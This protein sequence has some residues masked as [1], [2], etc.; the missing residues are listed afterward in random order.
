MA[1]LL[2]RLPLSHCLI[3]VWITIEP[4]LADGA[5]DPHYTLTASADP[6]FPGPNA[7]VV[8]SSG[9]PATL[10]FANG[11]NS[12]W[13]APRQDAGASNTVGNYTYRTAFNLAPTDLSTTVITGQ[14]AADDAG[15]DVLINGGS[16]G[17]TTGTNRFTAFTPF[18][19]NSGFIAGLNTLDFRVSNQIGFTGVRV[20]L[21]GDTGTGTGVPLPGT[22]VPEPT[23]LVLLGSGLIGSLSAYWVRKSIMKRT[24]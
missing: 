23:S 15:I 6:A 17:I 13:I 9:P 20:E 22:P 14:W 5:V 8:N 16:T 24:A 11:P 7:L 12:N 4:Y 10:W 19:I 18:T 3:P 1:Q 21:S 2:R